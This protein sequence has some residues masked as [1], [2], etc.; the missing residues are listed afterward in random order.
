MTKI[1]LI[2]NEV[3]DTPPGDAP[4]EDLVR[5][6]IRILG[7]IK[8]VFHWHTIST[9][10]V[11]CVHCDEIFLRTQTLPKSGESSI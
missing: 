2:R 9:V 6:E 3:P 8:S 10:Q 4:N 7:A 11:V 1:I 5:M